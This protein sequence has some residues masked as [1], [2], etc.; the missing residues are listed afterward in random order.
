MNASREL[1]PPLRPAPDQEWMCN[2]CDREHVGE[3]HWRSSISNGTVVIYR[4]SA[5]LWQC[6]RCGAEYY[7]TN[8]ERNK[9]QVCGRYAE[10]TGCNAC[11]GSLIEICDTP[12]IQDRMKTENCG[13]CYWSTPTEVPALASIV[14][15]RAQGAGRTDT[16]AEC[17][18][19]PDSA[20][21]APTNW[22]GEWR[23]RA[24]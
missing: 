14:N 16:M 6:P 10:K 18:R 3:E 21:K 9:Q 15:D 4:C 24:E 13:N 12:S 19:F 7:G 22:C 20:L 8:S 23:E 11:Y 5:C 17:A 2:D 1:V